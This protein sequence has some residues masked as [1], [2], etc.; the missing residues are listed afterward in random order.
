MISKKLILGKLTPYTNTK[1]VLVA[2]QDATDIIDGILDTHEKY[3]SEYDK[4]YQYFVGSDIEETANNIWEF[5]KNNVPY[6]I[7]PEETQY[8]KSPASI[9]ST[10]GSDCKSYSLMSMGLADS[11]RRNTGEDFTIAYR[12]A[13]YDPLD[14][15]P[16]HVFGV[17]NPGTNN[18]IWIDPVLDQF[19]QK[20]QP[21]YYKDKKIKNMALVALAGVKS[22]MGDLS[23]DTS[24]GSYD[25][26]GNYYDASGNIV[27]QS[28][29]L[30]SGSVSSGDTSNTNWLDSILK[31]A[32]SI[33][34]AFN[35]QP[36]YG[37]SGYNVIPMSQNVQPKTSTGI[38]TNTLFMI[39]AIG[40][41][42]YFLTKKK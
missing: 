14:S 19:N 6:D 7:E 37:G 18:E 24:G 1:K 22:K 39:G 16:Q 40:L 25:A 42:V 27:D 35:P 10:K 26:Y 8:L 30:P 9:L 31:S 41:G 4:I 32:P 3:K 36:Q 11:I 33:I 12:F 34:K 2:N 15:T 13:S 21:Y 23:Y 20:K 28:G 38:S 5:L 29:S 17:I